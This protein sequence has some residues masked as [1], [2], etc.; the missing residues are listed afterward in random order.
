VRR[1][2]PVRIAIPR[3]FEIPMIPPSIRVLAASTLLPLAACASSS[4][5]PESGVEAISLRPILLPPP[6]TRPTTCS[7]ATAKPTRRE[8][9][10]GDEV[11]IYVR[12]APPGSDL[13]SRIAIVRIREGRV[14]SAEVMPGLSPGREYAR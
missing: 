12:T 6:A 4:A 1:I 8:P 11:W 9:D 10:G 2:L 13:L 7:R 5:R 3:P 14:A